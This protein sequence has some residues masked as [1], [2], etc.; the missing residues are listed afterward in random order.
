MSGEMEL[1][2]DHAQ[3]KSETVTTFVRTGM[4]VAWTGMGTWNG[5]TG[6]SF[7]A[8]AVDSSQRST[9]RAERRAT[10]R[11]TTLNGDRLMVTIRDAEGN[12]VFAVAGPVTNGNIVVSSRSGDHDRVRSRL[13]S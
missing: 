9:Y 4:T 1:G 5:H 13:A 7:A 2:S 6:Y 11:G 12:V 8:T 3:F 10:L